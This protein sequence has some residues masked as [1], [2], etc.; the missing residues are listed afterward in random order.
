MSHTLEVSKVDS[1]AERIWNLTKAR[2]EAEAQLADCLKHLAESEAD[3]AFFLAEPKTIVNVELLKSHK[4]ACRS[5]I[6]AWEAS[7]VAIQSDID[8][9]KTEID[10][11][12]KRIPEARRDH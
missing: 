7:I 12:V 11:I 8:T 2:V 10:D 6:A 5:S 9:Y 3:L 4:R 1:A